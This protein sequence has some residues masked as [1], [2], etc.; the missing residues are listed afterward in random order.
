MQ[1]RSFGVCRNHHILGDSWGLKW[2]PPHTGRRHGVLHSIVADVAHLSCEEVEDA[3]GSITFCRRNVLIIEIEA[4]AIGGYIDRAESHF[5]L[6][7]EL[8]TL[9][10][11]IREKR[12]EW[13][14][15]LF[16]TIIAVWTMR[17]YHIVVNVCAL[18]VFP[19]CST[20]L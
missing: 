14:E 10:V 5:R 16:L 19:S 11:F 3:N 17:V 12:R 8:R 1:E 4:N 7:T 2:P 9:R 20:Y 15:I 6:D 13:F 18:R